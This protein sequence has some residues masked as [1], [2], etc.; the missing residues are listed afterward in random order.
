[1]ANNQRYAQVIVDV[2]TMQVN[3]PFDYII[4][5]QWAN[6]VT[7]GMRVQVPFGVREVL[8][9]VVEVSDESNIDHE[10]KSISAV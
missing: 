8:G 1:M 9:F 5:S 2:P 10:L 6:F 4:P 3:H 7:P